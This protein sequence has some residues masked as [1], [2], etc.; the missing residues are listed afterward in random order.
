MIK[1]STHQL[2]LSTMG[3]AIVRDRQEA[4]RP[5]RLTKCLTVFNRGRLVVE[6]GWEC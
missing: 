3:D 2:T 5:A 1:P 6:V 4:V